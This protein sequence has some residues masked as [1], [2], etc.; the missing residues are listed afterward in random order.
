MQ[1]P[2]RRTFPSVADI[3]MGIGVGTRATMVPRIATNTTQ[4]P[5]DGRMTH[6]RSTASRNEVRDTLVQ[7]HPVFAHGSGGRKRE[8]TREKRWENVSAPIVYSGLLAH[9]HLIPR[10]WDGGRWS[11]PTLPPSLSPMVVSLARR[12]R[13][14]ALKSVRSE[15]VR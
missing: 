10:G 15:W 9:V 4:P 12:G 11:G 13:A 14:A 7:L 5:G 6:G 8:H 3:C 2:C 1:G